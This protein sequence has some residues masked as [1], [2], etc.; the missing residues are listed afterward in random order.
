MKYSYTQFIHRFV[1]GLVIS[2]VHMEYAPDTDFV[3]KLP[4]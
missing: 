4:A 3:G 2:W 1:N